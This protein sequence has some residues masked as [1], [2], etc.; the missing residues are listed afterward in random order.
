[1]IPVLSRPGT[2]APAL[3][4]EEAAPPDQVCGS[5]AGSATPIGMPITPAFT[6]TPDALVVIDEPAASA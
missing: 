4:A 2:L 6:A 5:P 1:M 3:V